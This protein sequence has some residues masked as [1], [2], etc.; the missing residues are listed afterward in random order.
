MRKCIGGNWFVFRKLP[1]LVGVPIITSCVSC[2]QWEEGK[3]R[4]GGWNLHSEGIHFITMQYPEKYIWKAVFVANY[5]WRRLLK[6][7]HCASQTETEISLH[8]V[9]VAENELSIHNG[10]DLLFLSHINN[11]QISSHT[12][13]PDASWGK[14]CLGMLGEAAV[15]ETHWQPSHQPTWLHINSTRHREEKW[16]CWQATY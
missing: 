4:S 2:L 11:S 9:I 3:V 6:N 15:S 12:K 13:H 1:D 7:C 14:I 5:L 8:C 10:C 16:A